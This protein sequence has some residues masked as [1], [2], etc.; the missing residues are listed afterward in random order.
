MAS[1]Q[2]PLSPEVADIVADEECWAEIEA[3]L[4][5]T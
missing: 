3:P 5:P 2:R 1:V 4:A